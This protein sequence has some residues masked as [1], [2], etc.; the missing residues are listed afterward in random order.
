MRSLG[1]KP[2]GRF[3]FVLC[4]VGRTKIWASQTV[5]RLTGPKR[6]IGLLQVV[7]PALNGAE[8]NDFGLHLRRFWGDFEVCGAHFSLQNPDV[9][10][11]QHRR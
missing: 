7:T 10:F 2:S 8:L 1:S 4:G 5:T 3:C 9:V 6:E 11:P